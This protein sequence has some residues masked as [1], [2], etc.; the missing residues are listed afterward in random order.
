MV[1]NGLE[2]KNM[3]RKLQPTQ[4]KPSPSKDFWMIM[5]VT[6]GVI[7]LCLILIWLCRGTA[8]A[9]EMGMI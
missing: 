6:G 5:G 8:L 1:I 4:Y 7:I 2:A 3:S 9:H